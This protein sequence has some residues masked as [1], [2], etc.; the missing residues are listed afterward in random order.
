MAPS[1]VR[2]VIYGRRDGCSLTYDLIVPERP[3]GAA[4]LNVIS[5]SWTS[6]WAP[7][8]KR[9]VK[10]RAFLEAGI[11]VAAVHHSAGRHYRIPAVVDDVKRAISHFAAGCADLGL[12]RNLIGLWGHSAA[13]HLVLAAGLQAV[14]S[15]EEGTHYEFPPEPVTIKAIVVSNAPTD[16]RRLVLHKHSIRRSTSTLLSRQQSPPSCW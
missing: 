12:D 15:E 13:G 5:Q 10:Y 9:A 4:V 7:P 11:A 2:D 1:I 6:Q 14:T 16:M 3:T 8:E